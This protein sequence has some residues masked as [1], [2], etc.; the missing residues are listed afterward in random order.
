[1]SQRLVLGSRPVAFRP[2]LGVVNG[3][4]VYRIAG[5]EDDDNQ[6]DPADT[7]DEENDDEDDEDSDD[8]E[9]KDNRD[10]KPRRRSASS[11]AHSESRALRRELNQLKREKSEREQKDREAELANKSEVERTTVERDDARSERDRLKETVRQQSIELAI[12]RAS[13]SKYEWAD[14][15]DVLNDRT[16]R[17]AI[18]M[19]EDGEIT[20][21]KEALKD[22]AKRKPH[23]LVKKSEGEDEGTKGNGSGPS[24]GNGSGRSGGNPTGGGQGNGNAQ[25]DRQRLVQMY[26]ALAQLPQS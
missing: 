24:G 26:P 7:G 12:I 11:R 10:K 8:T 22:L 25:A 17:G 23:F 16:L 1:M 20:G 3:Q 21:V 6:L 13:H 19:D 2:L 18:E 15:E 14:I 5:A 9:D 4:P